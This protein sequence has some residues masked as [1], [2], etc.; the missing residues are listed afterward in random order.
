MV[1]NYQSLKVRCFDSNHC[2]LVDERILYEFTHERFIKKTLLYGTF[3]LKNIF[4]RGR[5][6][7]QGGD[8]Y[9]SGCVS[10]QAGYHYNT[11][12]ELHFDL[13]MALLCFLWVIRDHNVTHSLSFSSLFSFFPLLA[14]FFSPSC[15]FLRFAWGEFRRSLLEIRSWLD[16]FHYLYN[17]DFCVF[18]YTFLLLRLPPHPLHFLSFASPLSS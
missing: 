12:K 3:K 10:F 16:D 9:H 8:S 11:T 1:Q 5:S 6:R 17:F 14:S 2:F 4:T 18:I 13:K 7:V 15:I